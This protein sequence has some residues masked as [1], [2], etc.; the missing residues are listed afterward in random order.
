MNA[1]VN[2]SDVAPTFLEA[3]GLPIPKMMSARSMIDLFADQEKHA[4]VEPVFELLDLNEVVDEAAHVIP[5]SDATDF[6]Q[7]R[8]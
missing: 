1:F 8:S 2:L 5:E 3:A 4:N 6:H 7:L